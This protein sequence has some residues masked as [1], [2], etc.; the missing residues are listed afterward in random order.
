MSTRILVG[1]A[2][3]RL[4]AMPAE[5]V[6]CCI[7]SPP[8]WRLRSYE[9]GDSMIGLETTFDAHLARLVEVF[10]EVRRVLRADATLWLNYGDAYSTG[11][12][13]GRNPTKTADVGGWQQQAAIGPRANDPALKPKDLMMMPARVALALQADGWWLRS[14]VVWHKPNPMPES[15]T[16]RPTSAHEKLYLLSKRATYF[17][18]AD[19]VR[20]PPT[21]RT[22]AMTFGAPPERMDGD[23]SYKC[24]GTA[25]AN[26]RNVWTIATESFPD[27]HFATFPTA[28]VEPCI[29]AGTSERG[30]CAKCGAPWVR[31][32]STRY[33]P[34]PGWGPGSANGARG[35]NGEQKALKPRPRLKRETETT[36]WRPSCDHGAATVPAVVL[37]CFGGSGTVG[38][39]A[40]RLGR[41][42]ILIEISPTYAAMARQRID[43]D[44]RESPRWRIQ[45]EDMPLFAEVESA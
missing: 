17:Y 7:T 44:L 16:D 31:E 2:L 41:D 30:V 4:R 18:D 23:R 11:T 27:A 21:G 39:V 19:A 5:S 25:G 6:H 10:R 42:A 22:D 14:E 28:L 24:D 13:A 40:Q 1:H 38:V 12:T 9:G 32:S 3:E 43:D 37:D 15:C 36:G 20:L 33:V 35:G 29:R 45:P 8:Y 34:A 26:L